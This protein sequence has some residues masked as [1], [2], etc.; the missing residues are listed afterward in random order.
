MPKLAPTQN[1]LRNTEISNN[2]KL[3]R[4]AFNELTRNGWWTRMNHECCQTCSM[5][6]SP[7]DKPCLAFTKQ[8]EKNIE[9][10]GEVFLWHSGEA[11]FYD[12]K[13]G[14]MGGLA[15]RARAWE[16]VAVLRK[17]GLKV[18]W[19]GEINERIGV[20]LA[21]DSDLEGYSC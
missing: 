18:N 3:L 10:L 16:A 5:H 6:V 12:S 11:I 8:N 14:G 1:D 15:H 9:L 13:M 7:D 4:K 19:S 21:S 17:H 2:R 20:M